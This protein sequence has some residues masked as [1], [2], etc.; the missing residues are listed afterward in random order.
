MCACCRDGTTHN[1]HV[2][3]DTTAKTSTGRH[4]GYCEVLFRKVHHGAPPLMLCATVKSNY[5]SIIITLLKIK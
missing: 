1:G 2:S 5:I 3:G 4:P